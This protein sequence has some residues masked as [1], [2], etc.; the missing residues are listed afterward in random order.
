MK[1]WAIMINGKVAQ[2]GIECYKK[3][4]TLARKLFEQGE[5]K[6]AIRE[7]QTVATEQLNFN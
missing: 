1:H 7:F 3:A 6:I 4:R 5:R 2:D